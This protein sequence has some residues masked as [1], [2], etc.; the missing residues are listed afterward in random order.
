MTFIRT[1]FVPFLGLLLGHH[2]HAQLA[3]GEW[4]DHF[5]YRNAVAVA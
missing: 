2:A 1:L 3:L 4:N 5:P